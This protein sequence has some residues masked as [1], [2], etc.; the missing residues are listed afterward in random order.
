M[1]FRHNGWIRTAV[2][3]AMLLGAAMLIQTLQPIAF[4]QSLTSG[5]ISGHVTDP[6]GARFRVRQSSSRTLGLARPIQQHDK[7]QRLPYGPAAARLRT[8]S[9]YGAGFQTAGTT[10]IPP[11]IGRV[12]G[13]VKMTL[14]KSTP[15]RDGHGSRTA[16]EH[17]K[18]RHHHDIQ[19]RAGPEAAESGQRSDLRRTDRSWFRHEHHDE[20]QWR[21]LRLW[22]LFFVRSAGHVE[23]LHGQRHV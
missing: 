22:K 21:L 15:D 10:T 13:D 17:G 20:Q 6:T 2:T 3:F 12:N 8:P 23:H 4:A 16:A 14:G 7:R 18:C 19:Y 9:L 1:Q 11:G 5:D